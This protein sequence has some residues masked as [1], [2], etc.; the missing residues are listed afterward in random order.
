MRIARL[1]AAPDAAREARVY[2]RLEALLLV[3]DEE[4]LQHFLA[5]TRLPDARQ[6]LARASTTVAQPV[7]RKFGRA[8]LLA[9][10]GARAA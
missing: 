7:A 5:H 1:A 2:R 9:L 3:A 4:V 6:P 10:P 8:V